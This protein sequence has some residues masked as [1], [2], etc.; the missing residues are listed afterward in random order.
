M[1]TNVHIYGREVYV[2]VFIYICTFFCIQ[3]PLKQRT[4]CFRCFAE[5]VFHYYFGH[6]ARLF[7]YKTRW[8][9]LNLHHSAE[10]K[11]QALK[12]KRRT[13]C[14]KFH[15]IGEVG[16]LVV[17]L[18]ATSS[19]VQGE[20]NFSVLPFCGVV[21]SLGYGVMNGCLW[22]IIDHQRWLKL[23]LHY[24]QIFLTIFLVVEL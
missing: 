5:N 21:Q 6:V 18:I 17:M 9:M 22:W 24:D 20:L 12:N 15:P 8:R 10:N 7:V 11:F 14:S 13:S 16:I 3:M 2:C 23:V 19:C 4:I 1:F